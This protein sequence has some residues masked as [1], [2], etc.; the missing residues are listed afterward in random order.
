M[1]LMLE[2]VPHKEKTHLS[3]DKVH[4]RERKIRRGSQMV[5]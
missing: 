2:R 3:D 5:A 1:V 4:G